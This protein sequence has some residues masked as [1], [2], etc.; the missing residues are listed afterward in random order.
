M[1]WSYLS[2]LLA[3]GALA[4]ALVVSGG[5]PSSEEKSAALEPRVSKPK[6]TL[7]PADEPIGS[8]R[9]PPGEFQQPP[10]LPSNEPPPKLPEES[11]NALPRSSG[12]ASGAKPLAAVE[13]PVPPVEK[14]L[15]PV[16]KT[17]ASPPTPPDSAKVPPLRTGKHSDVPFDPVQVNGS[18]F[19]GW[20]KPRAAI[21]LTGMEH[22]YIEPCGC[23]GLERMMGGMSRRYTFLEQLRKNG[24]SRLAAV[25]TT[26]PVARPGTDGWPVAALDVGGLARGYGTQATLEFNTLVESKNKMSYGAVTFGA[27]DLRLPAIEIVNVVAGFDGKPSVFVSA[28][29][30]LYGFDEKLTDTSRIVKAGDIKIGVTGVLGRRYQKE[31]NNTD[32]VMTDPEAAL[33]KVVPELKRNADYLVLLAHATQ[34]ESVALAKRFPEFNVVVT[35]DGP[36]APPESPELIAGTRTLLVTVGQKGTYAI[37]LGLYG[38]GQPIRTQRVPLDSRFP[39][40]PEMK[41][42][43]AT[44]QDHLKDQGFAKLAPPPTPHPLSAN[45]RFVGAKKCEECHETPWKVWKKSKHA[46]AYETLEKLDTPRNFDPECVSCHVVGWHPSKSFPYVSGFQS[47]EKTPLL[48]GVGCED[49]HGPGERHI[50]AEAGANEALKKKYQQALHIT[51]E[52]FK[53]HQCGTCHD[54]DNSPD[55]DFD[56]YWPQIEHHKDK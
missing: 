47:R 18:I 35:S 48:V 38:A 5:C 2:R 16:P 34:D 20:P 21:V 13:K 36:A 46:T 3:A 31:I 23:A 9:P 45:G 43:M 28:N 15:V 22:G 27:G 17:L 55:F 7:S 25:G 54:G 49:C 30:A 32:V 44:Y 53:K 10:A 29:V 1:D 39:A 14:P 51:K 33:A 24:C 19:V 6:P 12:S 11:A 37:V 4:G 52:D 50:A 40:A 56:A 8:T 41:K 26:A 42:L